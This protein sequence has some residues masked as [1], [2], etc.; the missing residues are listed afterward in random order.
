MSKNIYQ[1]PK[2]TIVNLPE[3]VMQV[4]WGSKEEEPGSLDLQFEEVPEERIEE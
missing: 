1:K 4:A 3:K 2:A